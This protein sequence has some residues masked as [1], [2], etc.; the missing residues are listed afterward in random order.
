[1]S[2]DYDLVIRDATLIGHSS[3][4]HVD[5]C[6]SDGIVAAHAAPGSAT[7]A[8]VV[9]TGDRLVFPGMVDTH[10]HLMEPGDS[11]RENFVSGT[12]A[13][14]AAG[15]TTIVEHTHGW[16]V[17]SP[18]RLAEKR[19]T[20]AGRSHVDYGLAAHVTPANVDA[21]PALWQAGVSFFKMFTCTTHGIEGMDAADLLEAFEVLARTDAPAL[22]HCEDQA[23]TARR[24]RDL[25]ATGRDDPA[26]IPE[27]RCREAETVAITT[28]AT[29]ASL[30]GARVAVAHASTADVLADIVT[31]RRHGAGI[32]AE[33]C[34]Q[35]VFLEQ[36]EINDLAGLRKFTPPARIRSSYEAQAMW[37]AINDG[38]VHHISTDH[39]PS[40]MDQKAD[41]SIWDVH[42]GLPGLDT[43]FRLLFDAATRGRLSFEKIVELYS[44]AP[45]RFYGLTGKGSLAVGAAA[46]LVIVDPTKSSVLGQEAIRSG[47]RW[48]P[49]AGRTLTGKVT[50][51]YLRGKRIYCHDELAPPDGR[52]V[53]G[54]GA[55]AQVASGS[56][57]PVMTG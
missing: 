22:V 27:W 32:V 48:T 57:S 35:Y 20:L 36:S 29:L 6:V 16:P 38:R 19:G 21:I 31:A 49:Y 8:H 55:R 56:S 12:A 1:M 34:P 44:W 53:L 26:L 10:V 37:A 28:T 18:D 4:R 54:P 25:R 30:T 9:D 42:F 13:A 47:A 46:D 33:T 7:A 50:E 15:V 40:T 11:S 2:A 45:A 3:R 5:L 51:V 52:F 24:E 23:I 39:A 43:T 17:T 41:G 14:A